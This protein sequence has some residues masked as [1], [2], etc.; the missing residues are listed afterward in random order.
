M[1]K[2]I[3]TLALGAAALGLSMNAAAQD[4]AASMRTLGRKSTTY[5]APR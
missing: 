3:L 4:A 1:K 5:S 2:L